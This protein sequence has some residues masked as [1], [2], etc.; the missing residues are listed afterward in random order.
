MS[1]A[2]DYFIWQAS[3]IEADYKGSLLKDHHGDTGENRETII[4]KWLSNHLPKNVSVEIGGK[5]IDIDEN[6]SKQLDIIIYDNRLPRFGSYQKS[7]YFAE[8]ITTAIEVKSKLTSSSLKKALLNLGSALVCNVNGAKEGSIHMGVIRERIPTG[9]FA[10]ENGYASAENLLQ[11]LKEYEDKKLPTVDF[12]C[13]NKTCYI[14]YNRGTWGNVEE[15]G[16]STPLPN[17]YTIVTIGEDCI[18]RLVSGLSDEAN[19]VMVTDYDFQKYFMKI[20][21]AQ[22][23]I[24]MP[25]PSPSAS[26]ED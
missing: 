18:W 7:Y 25:S 24:P 6:I 23:S 15:N 16:H 13:I 1:V 9:I 19:A 20:P 12:V 3:R 26:P 11:A 14:A 21:S 22:G 5:A 2:K 10:F 8:G 17:G 4:C